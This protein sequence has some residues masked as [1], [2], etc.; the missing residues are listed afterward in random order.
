MSPIK[1]INGVE[2]PDNLTSLN[3]VL[4]DSI[5]TV[6]G[7]ELPE[8]GNLLDLYTG[9]KAAYSFR[10]LDV[11]YTGNCIQVQN[12]SGNNANIGFVNGVLDTATMETHCNGGFGYIKVW[13]DQS[14]SST[15]RDMS[16]TAQ[17]DMPIIVDSSG[18]T[19]TDSNSNPMANFSGGRFLQVGGPYTSST[20]GGVYSPIHTNGWF[21][22]SAVKTGSSIGNESI[23]NHDNSFQTVQ[24]RPR[25]AQYLR[26]RG[27]NDT[28]R[29]IAFGFTTSTPSSNSGVTN[30]AAQG[31]TLQTATVHIISGRANPNNLVGSAVDGVENT[32]GGPTTL[33]NATNHTAP[34]NGKAGA[35]LTMGASAH[36]NNPAAFFTG[37]IME[38]ILWGTDLTSTSR[39]AIID[40]QKTYY[41]V[42]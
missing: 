4:A 28:A 16:Q 13:Y 20:A 33:N 7:V 2:S 21:A 26:T 39:T 29:S 8:A 10:L 19:I 18:N 36:S 40:N 5:N 34:S 27:S 11:D 37:H 35:K 22:T 41:S 17:S 1:S 42:S 24:S 9:S 12:S 31:P 25:F 15:T 14:M 23:L 3:K 32:G 6:N 30:A 38:V